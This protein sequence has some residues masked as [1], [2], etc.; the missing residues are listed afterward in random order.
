MRPTL[1]PEAPKLCNNCLIREATRSEAINSKVKKMDESKV[2]ILVECPKEIQKEIEEICLN[3]NLT[4]SAYF[5]QLHEAY[6]LE[7]IEEAAS[8]KLVEK[9]K[10]NKK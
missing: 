5:L 10:G 9:H 6:N 2:N 3:E 1:D 8:K 7:E 4:F